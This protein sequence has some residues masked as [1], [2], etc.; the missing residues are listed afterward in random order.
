MKD[1]KTYGDLI[2]KITAWAAAADDI[3]G[4]VIIGSRAR[5]SDP[6][7]EYSDLD[8]LLIVT[9]TAQFFLSADWIDTIGQ[10]WLWFDERTPLGA[11]E[12][13]VLFDHALDVDFA[14]IGQDDLK[15]VLQ[16]QAIAVLQRGYRIL[17]DKMELQQELKRIP[18]TKPA[19]QP[20]EEQEF[21][22]IVKDF[23]YHTVWCTKKLLRGEI[24]MAKSCLDGYMKRL[25]LR[26]IECHAHAK[27]G[28]DY[29]TW[30][31]GRF[32][33]TWADQQVK[34]GIRT[35]FAHYDAADIVRALTASMDLFRVI[36]R[37]TADLM[38]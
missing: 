36:A 27:Q 16:T 35:A 37:E 30:F 12:R 6:A 1:C 8:L 21:T 14:F 19:V 9:D 38:S 2:E 33:D 24:W 7:D 15:Q 34:A 29:D 26:I 10:H 3:K 20:L 17:V 5:T 4:V 25:L 31:D 11:M 32:F 18:Q 28:W 13:R 22:N 23:W